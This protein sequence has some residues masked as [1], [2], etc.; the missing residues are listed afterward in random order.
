MIPGALAGAPFLLWGSAWRRFNPRVS[1][2]LKELQRQRALLQEHLAWLDH[3]IA[4]ESGRAD[5]T[6]PVAAGPA[7]VTFSAPKPQPAVP[8][9]PS[10]E[11]AS[12][13]TAAAEA[14]IE[15]YQRTTPSVQSEVK[16]GCFLYFFLALALVGAG[17][18]ALYLYTAHKH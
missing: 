11:S 15:K 8:A 17:V 10:P 4:G 7:G 12:A 5:E 16:R 1:D 2:R 13:A 3:E 14:I 18:L 6:K 9:F